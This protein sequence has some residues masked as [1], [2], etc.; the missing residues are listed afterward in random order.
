MKAVTIAYLSLFLYICLKMKNIDYEYTGSILMNLSGIPVRIFD[1]EQ[2][3]HF[4]Y[5]SSFPADPYEVAEKDIAESRSHVGYVMSSESQYYGYVNHE[6]LR[7]VIGP[8]GLLPLQEQQ[9]RHIAF[10]LNLKKEE[11]PSFIQTM[12]SIVRMP[13]ASLLQMLCAINYAISS[14]KLT[15]YDL[16]VDPEAQQHLQSLPAEDTDHEQSTDDE[17]FSAHNSL[18]YEKQMLEMVRR[19]DSEKLEAWLRNAPAI[20]AGVISKE[21]LQQEKNLFICTATLVSRAAIE[22]GMDGDEALNLSDSY[23]RQCEIMNSADDIRNLQLH[24]LIRYTK[25]VRKNRWLSDK[26]S[27]IRQV[28]HYIQNHLSDP[29]KTSEIADALYMSRSHLSARFHK[30]SGMKLTDYI[31]YVKIAEAKSLLENTGK[32]AGMIAYYLGYSSQSHFT[33]VFKKL[34]AATP[35]QYRRQHRDFRHQ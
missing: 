34:T 1:H 28:S 6:S 14:E 25:E 30:E 12:R 11:I 21:A 3:I 26:S 18:A 20:R 2:L 8:T 19:G 7:I 27:L 35:E 10:Q 24:M 32:P 23:I 5:H 13:L 9:I 16:Q 15:L 22:G 4:F 29:V 33:N 31:D 17:L